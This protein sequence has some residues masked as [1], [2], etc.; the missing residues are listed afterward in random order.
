MEIIKNLHTIQSNEVLAVG[1]KA[2]SLGHMMRE[3]IP[4]PEGFVIT[5]EGFDLYSQSGIPENIKEEVYKAFDAL[6]TTFVAVRS[7]ATVEDDVHAAWAGQFDTYLYVSKDRVIESIEKCWASLFSE[8]ARAYAE[9][10]L[11]GAE[12]RK[13]AVV[14]QK[15]INSDASGVAFSVHPVTQ[16]KDHI[17]IEAVYGLGE[18]VVSGQSTPDT[19]VVD[20]HAGVIIERTGAHKSKALFQGMR[21]GV[22]W[23]DI[24]E[25]KQDVSVLTNTQV[26]TLAEMV[27]RVE[28]YYG[29]P[30]DVEWAFENNTLYILQSRPITTLE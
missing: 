21:G 29:F 3:G 4:V 6:H 22:E 2:A 12:H 23:K 7:S 10:Y 19:Y 13:M 18:G 11:E 16:N 1:G 26:Q 5:T 8:R 17:I 28:Q 15:M 9:M 14:V 25:E 20:K 27:K 24:S 30:C